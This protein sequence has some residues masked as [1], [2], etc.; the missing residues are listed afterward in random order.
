M[1]DTIAKVTR[2]D[3]LNAMSFAAGSAAILSPRALL[4]E[5]IAP[6]SE[7]SNEYYPP[8]LTGLRG[9]HVGSF[10]T[11]HVLAWS[12][13]K[14]AGYADLD[15]EYDLVVV[16]AGISGLA[17]AY[18]YRQQAG[19]S[20]RILLLDNHDDFGGHAK[21]NEF[22]FDD[23]MLLGVGGSGNF[24]DSK[25][26]AT[27]TKHLLADL[28]IDLRK[29]RQAMDPEYA[30]A[31]FNLPMGMY[32]DS[33]TFGTDAITT[34][35]WM[36]AW[37]GYGDYRKLLHALPLEQTEQD[38]LI[39]FI[40]GSRPL[41]KAFPSREILKTLKSISYK[42]FL[43]DYVGLSDKTCT[44]WVP[45]M[46]VTYCLGLESLSLLE[47]IQS[48]LPGLSI[49]GKEI[50]KALP[51]NKA[52]EELDVVWMPDGNATLTRQ[53]VR[54]LIPGVAR[55]DTLESLIDARFDYSQLDRADQAVRLRLNSSV[56]NAVNNADSTVSV[57]YVTQG[58]AYRVKARH[59][60]LAC[61][62]GLISHVCPDLPEEQ[63]ENLLYNVKSPLISA[64][65]LL[66]N[67]QSFRDAGSQLYLCPTSY[68]KTVSKA[69]PSDI[70][71]YRLSNNREAPLVVYMLTSPT[72]DNDGTQT[73]RDLFRLARRQVYTT[74]FATYEE[75]IRT[76]LTGM[77][78][79]TG[80]NADRDIVAITVNRWP[81]GYGYKRRDL[82]DPEW[83]DGEAPHELGRKQFGSISIAN[84]D[85][86]GA[87]NLNA[88]II[89]AYRAVKEQLK[90]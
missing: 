8:S 55:G 87:S 7:I 23:Q 15:E 34:G 71:N 80:F 68:F 21:R 85:S 33:E 18:F 70:G 51:R 79:A 24:Q 63:R 11:S 5:A 13:N 35:Q 69:P 36:S 19:D 72:V 20:M 82:Y 84:A 81:H 4:A 59:C 89:A 73:A 52:S 57:S 38:K 56:V 16:G 74:S 10:E 14:P 64:N 45:I 83:A 60:V 29:A 22:H 31:N 54:R 1:R 67:G 37:H 39:G 78:G 17:A 53:M 40:E 47:G 76:Q 49:L 25:F 6:S 27:E 12:G 62:N 66:R 88:A 61:Y 65:V 9:S 46:N 77:F 42:A 30:F 44:L 50:E 41:L 58:R 28:G 48:G 2:R 26:Y 86:E 3:F 75:E 43:K 90:T 32:T